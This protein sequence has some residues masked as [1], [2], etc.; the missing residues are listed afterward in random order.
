MSSESNTRIERIMRLKRRA[1]KVGTVVEQM[2]APVGI[3]DDEAHKVVFKLVK[4][5]ELDEWLR[6]KAS[7]LKVYD[8]YEIEHPEG[9]A[10]R[11]RVCQCIRDRPFLVQLAEQAE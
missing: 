6:V 9:R 5:D 11:L 1:A 10:M 7:P 4:M 3:C 2:A 8:L